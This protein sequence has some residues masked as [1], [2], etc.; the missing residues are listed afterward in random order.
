MVRKIDLAVHLPAGEW[1][2]IQLVSLPGMMAQNNWAILAKARWLRE[3]GRPAFIKFFV[4]ADASAG[5]STNLHTSGPRLE[6]VHDRLRAIK[7]HGA[8]LPVVPILVVELD[9]EGLLVA[10]DEVRPLQSLIERGDAH[11]YAT[12]VLR[13]LDPTAG[14]V[15][16]LHFDLCG[17]NVGVMDSGRV[18]LIDLESIYLD[19]AGQY[20]VTVPGWK[21]FRAP[22]KLVY[23]VQS[24][25]AAG[26]GVPRALAETKTTFEVVLTAAECVLGPLRLRAPVL[27]RAAVEAWVA[28][29]RGVDQ[30]AELFGNT[31][32]AFIDRGVLP[33]LA[34]FADDV[35][36]LL[37]AREGN[38]PPVVV[39]GDSSLG[40]IASAIEP[41]PLPAASS[42]STV[43]TA[44]EPRALE[45]QILAPMGNA[46]RAGRLD[47]AGIRDY[48]NALQ[49]L[50]ELD[51]H[52]REAWDELVLV[53]VAYEK[54]AATAL[55]VL[56]RAVVEFPM[57]PDLQRMR[58]IVANWAMD[59]NR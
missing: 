34:D 18:V 23:D 14:D 3:G 40:S 19:D 39:V 57:D 50:V 10:M 53:L 26:A 32:L 20:D 1:A 41:L 28:P 33:N 5:S 22:A 16:W 38:A 21:P 42:P 6:H 55:E 25:L 45:R 44:P 35:E 52:D 8:T 17:R 37:S 54:D 59:R 13:D 31:I 2:D 49:R 43:S 46:L 9:D 29:F 11:K 36:R 15:R 48:G 56:N 7:G 58:T 4:R 30:V 27:Q 12:R 51:P 47:W 24:A